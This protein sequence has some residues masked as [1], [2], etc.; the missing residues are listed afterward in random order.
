MNA[1]SVLIAAMFAV[2][3]AGCEN[4]G[5][6]QSA[7]DAGSASRDT[8]SSPKADWGNEDGVDVS[9]GSV[10]VDGTVDGSSDGVITD[11][12]DSSDANDGSD[13]TESSDSNDA[14]NGTFDCSVPPQDCGLTDGQ[15]KICTNITGGPENIWSFWN[16]ETCMWDLYSKSWP[17]ETSLVYPDVPAHAPGEIL[18]MLGCSDPE[19]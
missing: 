8:D 10:A 16:K 12:S 3:I 14:S 4:S 6:Q 7:G 9:D 11:G 18:S 19:S 2:T 13:A 15:L 5:S 1:A 17:K